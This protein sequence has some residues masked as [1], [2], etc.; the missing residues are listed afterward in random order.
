[1]AG[2]FSNSFALVKA[3]ANVLRLDK[4]LM[5]FPLMSG[6]ATVLVAASFI[7]PIFMIGP[8]IFVEGESTSYAAYVLG[9]AFYLV[10]YFV[11][12]FFNA[13][14]VGAALIRLDGGDPTVSDGLAIASKRAGSILGYAAIAATVGMVLRFIA[15]RAGFLGRII[16]GFIGLAWTLTT[17]L[18]VPILVTKDIGPVDA[19]KE[20]VAVFKRTWGEQV[21]GNFG[22]S[23][24]VTLMAISW[25]CVGFVMMF[26]TSSLG[27]FGVVPVMV[28]WGFGYVFLALFASAL[29]GI[30]TA[31]LYRY[32]ITGDA[33][34]FDASILGNAFRPK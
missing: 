10:Q 15:E 19:V 28:I 2:R 26:L 3:S 16:T 14:L 7:A 34:Y 23:L 18:T 27:A 21:V 33:G 22:M 4:E 12:F 29:S 6:I 20:S 8:E 30:Y 31:A 13:A 9:F 5:V 32:A 11:I 17:Y 1:M 24:A 25:T